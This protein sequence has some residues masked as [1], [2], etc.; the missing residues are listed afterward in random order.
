MTAL[1]PYTTRPYD[2]G[3]V[4]DILTGGQ[5]WPITPADR[6]EAIRRLFARGY[7]YEA[8]A[9]RVRCSVKTVQRAVK[10]VPAQRVRELREGP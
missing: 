6:H 9:R 5:P 8:I 10:V 1:R 2:E 3:A 7:E 4:V